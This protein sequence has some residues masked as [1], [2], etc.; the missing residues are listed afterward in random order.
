MEG[1]H[2]F[3][4]W[5]V[6]FIGHG[7]P[8]N[9]L[10]DNEFTQSWARLGSVLGR[11]RAIVSISAHWYTRGT[12]VTAMPFPETIYD[13]GYTNMF[14]LKYPAPGNPALAARIG[15]LLDPIAVAQDQEWGFDHGTWSVLL[16]AYPAAEIPVVQLSID[17]TR[18]PT[19]HYQIGRRL[20]PL[21]EE[22]ILLLGTGNIVHNLE[23][24]IR[25]GNAQ[26]Y[27]WAARFDQLVR[28]KLV[29]RRWDELVDYLSLSPDV[30]FAV[31]TPDHFLPLLYVLGAADP[32]ESLSFPIEAIDRGSM[33][34]R[35]VVIGAAEGA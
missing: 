22:G 11:P 19:F 26:P 3:R 34:M 2:D 13:F 7:T 4:R 15:Q 24:S 16:K 5:P 12:R 17:G 27:D 6:A 10:A 21:R 9:A 14:H 28:E 32:A 30:E 1:R 25:T 23:F 29:E 8:L 35:S 18:G 33:A 20:A 31:P